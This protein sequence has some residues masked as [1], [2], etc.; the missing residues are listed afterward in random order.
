MQLKTKFFRSLKQGAWRFVANARGRPIPRVVAAGCERYLAAYSN[1]RSHLI[2]HD[3]E[4]RILKALG[5]ARTCVLFDVGANVGEWT[6]AAAA[7]FPGA[8]I[9]AFEPVSTTAEML[10]SSTTAAGLAARVIVE[11]RGMSDAVGTA[12]ISVRSFSPNSSIL[13][14]PGADNAETIQLS[15]LDEYCSDAGIEK[16]DFLKID[17]EGWDYRVLLGA[18]KLLEG[19]RID[20]IQ[21]EYGAWALETRFL[22]K[23]FFELL[24][25]AGFVVGKIYPR[26]VDFGPYD[27]RLEDFAGLNYL[28]VR[29]NRRELISVPA[30]TRPPRGRRSRSPS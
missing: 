25:S 2:E 21:F 17:T 19:A 18:S 3:G 27:R 26:S 4:L 8:V 28:A 11:Q 23:D 12:E 5:H 9:H 15:T 30:S 29:H 10:R 6:M 22:L 20:V 14:A 1:T 16:V 24:E 7:I 13:D